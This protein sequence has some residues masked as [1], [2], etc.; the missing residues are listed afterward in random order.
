MTPAGRPVELARYHIPVGQ[1]W[2]EIDLKPP[3]RTPRTPASRTRK[4]PQMQGLQ[5]MGAV[6]FEPATSRV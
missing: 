6:G 4:T 2:A 5:P 1:Q 3:P